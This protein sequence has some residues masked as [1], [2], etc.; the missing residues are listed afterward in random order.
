[1][2]DDLRKDYITAII[3]VVE[4]DKKTGLLYVA[5]DLTVVSLTLSEKLIQGPKANSTIVA[6]GLCFLLVSAAL[7]FNHYRKIHLS[8][9][10]IVD[11]L[12][13]LDTEKA[14]SIPTET[15]QK[16]KTGYIVGYIVRLA[17]VAMLIA[18]YLTSR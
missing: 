17:G 6:A 1:M 8:T 9:F 18:A 16:H 14:R 4:E 7:F 12:L 10:E 5:F 2:S 15:W 3:S 11:K 13:T